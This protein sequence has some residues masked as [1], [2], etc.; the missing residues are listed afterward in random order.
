MKYLQLC[1]YIKTMDKTRLLGRLLELKFKGKT[2]M[3]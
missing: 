2:P 3:G 1:G